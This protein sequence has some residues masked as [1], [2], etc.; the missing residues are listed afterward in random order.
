M[1]PEQEERL[2]SA[3]ERLSEGI[4]FLAGTV[5]AWYRSTFPEK[6]Q[7]DEATVTHVMTEEEKLREE[8]GA[9]DEPLE[10]WTTLLGDREKAYLKKHP[11]ERE[12]AEDPTED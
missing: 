4:D 6:K 5:E 3:F 1:T 11:E 7:A 8:Q 9:S 12:R 2:V 10:A